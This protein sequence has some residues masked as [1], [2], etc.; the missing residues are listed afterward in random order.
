MFC[1]YG[2]MFGW[3]NT[4]YECTV[5][6]SDQW[7]SLVDQCSNWSTSPINCLFSNNYTHDDQAIIFCTHE[8]IEKL[9]LLLF[10]NC[11][12]TQY[13]SRNTFS[14]SHTDFLSLQSKDFLA[15]LIVWLR[16]EQ[17]KRVKQVYTHWLEKLHPQPLKPEPLAL[18]C[19]HHPLLLPQAPLL[20]YYL[21][22]AKTW[23][24]W[25]WEK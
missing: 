11:K 12:I 7:Q 24:T 21:R 20:L 23:R 9:R 6:C 14:H 13:R 22:Q 25:R 8:Q 4:C 16:R 1:E 17:S 15:G 3:M 19:F 18:K 10:I 2:P 5:V